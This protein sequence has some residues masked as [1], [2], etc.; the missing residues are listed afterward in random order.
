MIPTMEQRKN[1]SRTEWRT[2]DLANSAWKG[3]R[4]SKV[5]NAL[6][7]GFA[8]LRRHDPTA[9]LREAVIDHESADTA[10]DHDVHEAN[11]QVRIPA[12][13]QYLHG[14]YADRGTEQ[15]TEQADSPPS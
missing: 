15:A 8:Y 11:Q 14:L 2:P 5:V 1:G 3:R 6:D 4:A 12:R 13:P 9:Q 7:S 10:Q